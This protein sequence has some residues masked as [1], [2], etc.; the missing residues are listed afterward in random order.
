MMEAVWNIWQTRADAIGL[1]VWEH[2]QLTMLAL[3]IANL[4]A[5]PLGIW[6]TRYPRLAEP[7]IGVAAVAQTIP[8]LALLGFMIP[9][10][11]IGKMPAVIALTIYGLLPV[12]RNTYTGI[13]EVDGSVVQAGVGMGMTEWQI[14]RLIQL[15]L[16]LPVMMA[17]IRTAT[18]LLVG[19]A[20]LA[21]LIGGGGLGDL[22]F[23]GIAMANQELILA[24]AIPAAILSLLL[25]GGLRLLERQAQPKGLAEAKGGSV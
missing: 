22:I 15:P 23:R 16:A 24:G 11:G 9:I 21:A 12:V 6:L 17:G 4:L 19:I 25:D 13:R 10:F 1:A 20:T 14:L 5:V 18:V 3:V 7:I 2:V 8:S